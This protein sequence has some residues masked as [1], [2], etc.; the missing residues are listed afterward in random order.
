MILILIAV[1]LAPVLLLGAEAFLARNGTEVD[2]PDVATLTRVE[3]PVAPNGE[4]DV[5]WLGDSTAAAVGTSGAEHA[6]SSV[7]GVKLSQRCG[8]T[9]RTRV[10]AK[11][12]A[13]VGDVLANQVP[14]AEKLGADIVFISVGANDTIH[15]TSASRFSHVYAEVIDGLVSSGI[16]ADRIVLVG[17]PD[18]G[19]PPRLAQPLRAVMGFRSRRLDSR[20]QALAK[21]KGVRYVDLF[22]GTSAPIRANPPRYFAADDYHPN[23][24]GYEL[25]AGTI[26][27][28]AEPICKS[29]G[30]G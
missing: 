4:V 21:D 2:T 15:L 27:P 18:M 28:V 22:A 5:L 14:T 12:G 30:R 19:S 16:D 29:P 23:D 9:T 17:V 3:T 8:V 26:A 6:V 25:W 13:R 10:I 24:N 20:V 11:S 7:V 1:V